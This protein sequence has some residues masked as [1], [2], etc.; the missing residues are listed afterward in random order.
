MEDLLLRIVPGIEEQWQGTTPEALAQIERLAGRPL[1]SFY[2]WF[3]SRMGHSMGPLA[4]PTLDLSAQRVLTCYTEKLAV[5]DSRFL[6][7]GYESNE[8][9]PLHLFYD[10]D[11]ST[12]SDALVTKRDA[13]GG[14]SY[15]KF[16]TLCAML[17]WG[18][19][20]KFKVGNMPQECGGIIRCNDSG[21]LVHLDP[22]MNSLGFTTPIPTGRFCRLYERNDVAMVC[23]GAPK[24]GF[25]NVLAF[26]LAGSNAGTLRRI[27]GEIATE[28]SLEV[29]VKRWAPP[30]K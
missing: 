26:T 10:F 29:K 18:A 15:D 12:R 5:P 21:L 14:E 22:L 8:M 6:L 28:S 25:D 7:I 2:R 30:L 16:E 11:V 17:A 27:L 20:F 24:P 4:Y 9:M 23:N 19:F 1:P 13:E 3:L